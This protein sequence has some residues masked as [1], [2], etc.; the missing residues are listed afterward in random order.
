[1]STYTIERGKKTNRVRKSKVERHQP[2]RKLALYRKDPSSRGMDTTVVCISMPVEDLA[3]IDAA[4]ER[5]QMARSH[6]LRRAA[7]RFIEDINNP[8]GRR[9]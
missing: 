4:C 1:M 3:R 2:Q 7:E 8:S 6:F 5:V 9:Q